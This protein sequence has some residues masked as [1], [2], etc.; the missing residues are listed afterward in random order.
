MKIRGQRLFLVFFLLCFS[1]TA[2]AGLFSSAK[3]GSTTTTTETTIDVNVQTESGIKADFGY[4]PSLVVSEESESSSF[5]PPASDISVV[6]LGNLFGLVDG[7][8]HGSGSQ[9]MGIIFNVFNSAVLA[10]GGVVMMYIIIVSTMNTAHEGQMLG[11]KW[12]SIWVPV[13]ATM[14]LAL[15]IPKSSGY[16][17]MQIFVMW[18]VVQGVGIADKVWGTALDYLNRGG[19][20]MQAQIDPTLSRQAGIEEG[21]TDNSVIDGASTIFYGQVCMQ[22]LQIQLENQRKLDL[23][24]KKEDSGPCA[25]QPSELMQQFCDNSVPD[26]IGS[27][28]PLNAT[29]SNDSYSV[30]MP[31]FDSEPYSKLNGVCGTL[32][33]SAFDISALTENQSTSTR[34]TTTTDTTTTTT[35]TTKSGGRSG[36]GFNEEEAYEEGVTEQ[37]ELIGRAMQTS[38][39]NVEAAGPL[40][41]R[42]TIPGSPVGKVYAGLFGGKRG[43]KTTTEV[44]TETTRDVQSELYTPPP[45][46]AVFTLSA[47][48]FDILKRSRQAAIAQMYTTLA[49]TARTIVANDPEITSNS[50]DASNYASPVADYQFGVPQTSV[51]GA[52]LN[53]GAD[54]PYWGKLPGSSA[55]LLLDGTELQDAVTDYN[56]VMQPAL[57]LL[58]DFKNKNKA[59]EGRAFIEES[60]RSG[61]ILAGSYFFQLVRLN[62]SATA[63][64]NNVDAH[65]GLG[66]S[67]FALDGIN[68]VCTSEHDFN[69]LCDFFSGTE[70][71]VNQIIALFRGA[72]GLSV[73]QANL[74]VSDLDRIPNDETIKSPEAASTVYGYAN[75]AMLIDLPGQ[76]GLAPKKLGINLEKLKVKV[77]IDRMSKKTG[78]DCGFSIKIPA[79]KR[80]CI[81]RALETFGWDMARGIT[82]AFVD[83]LNIATN[84]A[85]DKILLLPL[86]HFMSIFSESMEVI[87]TPGTNPVLALA[88]MGVKYIN[89]SMDT[90]MGIVLV[91]LAVG[92]IPQ[93]GP[94]IM[95]ALPLFMVW[96][97][98]M[99]GIGF[100]TA[101]YI[102]FLPYMIFTFGALAWFIAVIEAMAAAPLVALGISH[103]EGH[104]ALG[105]SE[106]GL[107]I[108]LNVF[109]RPAMMVIGF[110]ASIAMCYVGVWLLNSGFSNVVEYLRSADVWAATE[111][112]SITSTGVPWSSMFGFFFVI[113]I[114][115]MI[116]LTLVE[117]SFSLIAVLPDKV[118]RW[119]GG[120]AEGV[121][122]EASQWTSETKQQVGK[123]ADAADKASGAIQKGMAGMA[124]DVGKGVQDKIGAGLSAAKSKLTPGK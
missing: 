87:T 69:A 101:Y 9:M 113:I 8:L 33:W 107:M 44:T 103:P 23:D 12:S 65:S 112:W 110:I 43:S 6:F 89:M 64:S 17:L 88:V 94:F 24:A 47:S 123:A 45:E 77:N 120:Q 41:A 79:V 4:D 71:K 18:V 27:V 108:L 61:W 1:V 67:T 82:N 93:I 92:W 73:P 86:Q 97:G 116:Y 85:L 68:G 31:N 52:C 49:S 115:T 36:W 98:I 21:S 20:I 100:T 50:G 14:G 81:G 78:I 55:P 72:S 5:A 16:C 111:S 22:A 99:V 91:I 75:N 46:D 32:R 19:V 57:K 40:E 124:V 38:K 105:K 119:V 118:L 114:Y 58:S 54:C 70:T 37:A 42:A 7:V 35:T 25:G 56:A 80:I 63:T 28:D 60:K 26:F 95:M 96:I 122:Q 66:T 51:Y 2:S 104:D 48:D 3:K 106:Q 74:S 39:N 90:W 76:S 53:T 84:F 59:R 13:R 121:G 62:D 83:G 15:L 34:T 102:P 10:M 117:K 11:Q 109:L 30:Q 29:P